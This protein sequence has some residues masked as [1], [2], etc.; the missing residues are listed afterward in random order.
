MSGDLNNKFSLLC[1]K[2]NKVQ[3]YIIKDKE[4]IEAA[5][6]NNM[7]MIFTNKRHFYH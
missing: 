7:F 6:Q 3:Y 5:D 2:M 1:V 4:V